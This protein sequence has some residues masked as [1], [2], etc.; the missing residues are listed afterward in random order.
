MKQKMKHLS[1]VAALALIAGYTLP[2]QAQPKSAKNASAIAPAARVP[3]EASQSPERDALLR[4]AVSALQETINALAELDKKDG[5]TATAALERAI[6]KLEI[7]LARN[8]N[9]ALAPADINVVT[10]DVLTS[11]DA[12]DELRKSVEVAIKDGRLQEARRLIAGLASEMVARVS[13]LPL[14][15]YPDAIRAAARLLAQGKNNEAKAAIETALSTIVVKE[16]IYPLPLMR[17]S[18]AIEAARKLAANEKRSAEDDAKIK[19]LLSTAREQV[20]LG[21]ALG[22]ARKDELKDLLK[23]ID[24]IEEGVKGKRS[25]AST[26]DKIRGLFKGAIES[27]QPVN[28]K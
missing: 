16:V 7:L 19:E 3:V 15:T 10:Q 13:Y 12:V 1:I 8:P 22:Y 17:A 9:L 23:T 2:V 28:Q 26:F 18:A 21:Q 5:K 4:D 20:R 25:A 24:K 6:G 11:V 27:S 14:A